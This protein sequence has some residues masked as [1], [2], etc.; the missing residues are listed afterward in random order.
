[1]TQCARIYVKSSFDDAMQQWPGEKK[2]R[3]LSF[4][5]K[6]KSLTFM[7]HLAIFVFNLKWFL[8]SIIG[9]NNYFDMQFQT[10]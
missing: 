10:F 8:L 6:E 2:W 9:V 5:M 7:H 1:M 3:K 4:P